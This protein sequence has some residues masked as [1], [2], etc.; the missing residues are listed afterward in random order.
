MGGGSVRRMGELARVGGKGGMGCCGGLAEEG[1][2]RWRQGRDAL[3][4]A[5]WG[6]SSL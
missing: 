2:L 1:W 6:R 5:G 3:A 4:T